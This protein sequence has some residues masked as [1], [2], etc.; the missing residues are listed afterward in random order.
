MKGVTRRYAEIDGFEYF[1]REAHFTKYRLRRHGVHKW[2][3]AI[4]HQP[5]SARVVVGPGRKPAERVMVKLVFVV[6]PIFEAD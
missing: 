6:Q 1:R 5:S 4:A 3:G 2:H